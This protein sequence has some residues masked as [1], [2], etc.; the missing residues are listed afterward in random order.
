MPNIRTRYRTTAMI[1]SMVWTLVT[2]TAS[3]AT[4]M[5]MNGTASIQRGSVGNRKR[6]RRRLSEVAWAP[7][8]R[9]AEESVLMELL[10]SWSTDID[11]GAR[12][13][14]TK[15]YRSVSDAGGADTGLADSG[16]FP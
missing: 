15:E 3:P 6:V 7:R 12:S 2:K 1:Q 11:R 4:W 9:R 10:R 5:P 13:A 16:Q 8:A 14:G